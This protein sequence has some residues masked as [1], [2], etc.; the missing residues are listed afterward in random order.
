F[1]NHTACRLG[2]WYYEGEGV[3]CYSRLPGYREM[4]NP[5]MRF[6]QH[7]VEAIR[8][9]REGQLQSAISELDKL[10]TASLDVL[11][12]LEQIAHSGEAD[13]QMLCAH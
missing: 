11:R 3:A 12:S 2:K 6:H 10:E 8:L 13:V 4:E 9:Y 1:A 5:H 7:G